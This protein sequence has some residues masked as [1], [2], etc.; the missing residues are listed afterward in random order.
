[1]R[2]PV[3]SANPGETTDR[4][5]IAIGP[6]YPGAGASGINA[7]SLIEVYAASRGL[8]NVLDPNAPGDADSVDGTTPAN[9]MAAT[10]NEGTEQKEEVI[11]DMISE[12]NIAPY[13]FENDGVNFDTMYP[14]GANQLD[15]LQLHDFEFITGTTVG[16]RTTL[17]G[18]LFPCGLIKMIAQNTG[19][20]TANL[21]FQITLVPGYHRGY[22]CEPMTEM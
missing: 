8:P 15:G 12:N 5:I 7:V 9:W 4:E 13:P 18:G 11:S 6:N 3:G 14:G 10:F 17:D 22:L 1:M 20:V 16:G 19:G 2:I 21:L